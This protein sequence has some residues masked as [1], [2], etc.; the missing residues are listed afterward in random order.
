MEIPNSILKKAKEKTTSSSAET[1]KEESK[2][3]EK[4]DF[5]SIKTL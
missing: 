2:F 5:H 4:K 1:R 3:N